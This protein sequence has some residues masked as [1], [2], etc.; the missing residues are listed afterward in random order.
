[1][2]DVAPAVSR[3]SRGS[4]RSPFIV[5]KPGESLDSLAH[6][7]AQGTF[8][9]GRHKEIKAI[10]IQNNQISETE[11]LRPGQLLNVNDQPCDLVKGCGPP[12]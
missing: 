6:S 4:G 9:V 7:M 11:P 3:G 5:V 1:M 12:A 10:L 2:P 8:R